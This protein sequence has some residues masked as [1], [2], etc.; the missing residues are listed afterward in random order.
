MT[1]LQIIPTNLVAPRP[2][3]LFP[4]Y[5]V[6]FSFLLLLVLH[7]HLLLVL[8]LHLHLHLLSPP[9]FCSGTF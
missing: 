4:V 3:H 9:S 1:I 5:R 7:L 6:S 2:L 8:H